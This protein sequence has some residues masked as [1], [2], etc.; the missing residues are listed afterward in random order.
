MSQLINSHGF[1]DISNLPDRK[2]IEPPSSCLV[3]HGILPHLLISQCMEPFL[4]GLSGINMFVRELCVH[5]H[6]I[7][8][9]FLLLFL[10]YFLQQ[11]T[12][13]YQLL[14]ELSGQ[15]AILFQLL[16]I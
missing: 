10:T 4:I 13:L 12:P 5:V 2:L 7:P 3:W 8:V 1:E 9:L 15:H 16:N 11:L 6:V 14:T